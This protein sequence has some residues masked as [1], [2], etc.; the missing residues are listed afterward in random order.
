MQRINGR[1]LFLANR[2]L[3]SSP[4]LPWALCTCPY[5]PLLWRWDNPSICKSFHFLLHPQAILESDSSLRNS[6][7]QDNELVEH[8]SWYGNKNIFAFVC[9]IKNH[10]GQ[11]VNGTWWRWP[12]LLTGSTS[13]RKFQVFTLWHYV[14]HLLF[15]ALP[16]LSSL[17]STL[18]DSLSAQRSGSENLLGK[19]KRN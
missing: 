18:P 10:S 3:R 13:L 6:Y 1:F 5:W 14:I 7:V 9:S 8:N 4:S 12:K 2:W 11:K 15:T 16:L 19:I 17:W